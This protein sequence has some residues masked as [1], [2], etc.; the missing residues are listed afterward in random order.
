RVER[1]ADHVIEELRQLPG[2]ALRPGFDTH[3]LHLRRAAPHGIAMCGVALRCLRRHG[4]REQSISRGER[5][6]FAEPD[7]AGD[8]VEVERGGIA[9]RRVDE[10]VP[11]GE[12]F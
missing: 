4:E 3:E 9:Q 1:L 6:Y 5:S 12:R 7:R 10:D 11:S 2:V 8:I